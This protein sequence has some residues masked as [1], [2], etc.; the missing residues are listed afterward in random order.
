MR[1]GGDQQQGGGAGGAGP[2]TSDG[3]AAAS[4]YGDLYGW[5]VD[6]PRE[7]HSVMDEVV[8]QVGRGG[9]N[10]SVGG[11]GRGGGMGLL[12]GVGGV[13]ERGLLAGVGVAGMGRGTERAR[14]GGCGKWLGWG[15]QVGGAQVRWGNRCERTGWHSRACGGIVGRRGVGPGKPSLR[16]S[17][18]RVGLR[19]CKNDALAPCLIGQASRLI[20]PCTPAFAD[21]L[22]V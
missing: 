8:R 7:V 18:T 10:G 19:R 11:C 16:P 21:L 12:A 15:V 13:G 1:T 5:L 22:D 20:A 17:A 14:M 4:S 3:T 2:S 6:F 9:G